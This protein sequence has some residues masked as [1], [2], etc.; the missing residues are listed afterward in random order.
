MTA[1]ERLDRLIEALER[2]TQG[3]A[4]RRYLVRFPG[5]G[6]PDFAC[7]VEAYEHDDAVKAAQIV[8]YQ[9]GQQPCLVR[10]AKDD[11]CLACGAQISFKMGNTCEACGRSLE[12]QMNFLRN[13]R[14]T[15]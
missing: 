8:L 14:S 13:P 10:P 5:H 6:G 11:D 9:R 7:V 12:Q 2:I 4:P 15:L 3:P 1:D